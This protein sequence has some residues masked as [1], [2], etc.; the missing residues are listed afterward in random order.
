MGQ[1]SKQTVAAQ[2]AIADRND[3]LL[4]PPG[5]Q[6]PPEMCDT[7]SLN[8]VARAAEQVCIYCIVEAL[9]IVFLIRGTSE[10]L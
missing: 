2:Q 10:Y 6:F 4:L 8:R 5:G 7:V 9:L 1:I 3:G